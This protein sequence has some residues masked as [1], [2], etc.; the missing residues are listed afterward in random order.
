MRKF[1][2]LMLVL[3]LC[4]LVILWCVENSNEEEDVNN[5]T[6][7]VPTEEN[8]PDKNMPEKKDITGTYIVKNDKK[9]LL[10]IKDNGQYEL[11]INVCEGYLKIV[12]NYEVADKKL[13]LLNDT[14]YENY[15]NIY[16]NREFSF[17]I[18][19]DNTIRLDEDLVCLFQ[20]TLFE[21]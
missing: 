7:D 18:L 17:T 2:Y 16:K 4:S 1:F 20:N 3:A 15:E 21:R 8:S 11:N 10:V 9:S 12:G 13:R 5:T 14:D 6:S 19:D